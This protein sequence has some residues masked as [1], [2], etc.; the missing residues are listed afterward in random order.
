MPGPF[1]EKVVWITGGGSGIGRACAREFARQGATVAVSGRRADRLAEVVAELEALGARALAVPCDVCDEEQQERAVTTIVDALGGLDVAM[2]N[3]GFSV[4][5]R[6]EQLSAADW[7]RQFEVNVVGAAVTVRQALPALR[8][9][10]GRLVLTGS[11]AGYIAGPGF[12]A[13]HASKYAIRALG[14]T[15]S[16]ELHGSGVSCTTVHPGFVESE[17]NKV[18]NEGH[19]DDRREEK[20]PRQL[21]WPTDRAARVI[22]RAVEK[23]K[24]ELVFTAHGKLGAFIGTHFPRVAHFFMT[25]ERSL[26]QADSFHVGD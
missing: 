3:A 10:A 21:L 23:R 11:V 15:L 4:G 6:I 8:A 25:R 26:Q 19:F 2:A 9:S 7:R 1:T 5:G 18:D 12:G 16:A 14:R 13:Y 24:R 20:R 17:I 22:V